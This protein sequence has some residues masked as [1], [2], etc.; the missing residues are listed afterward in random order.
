MDSFTCSNRT[1]PDFSISKSHDLSPCVGT[2]HYRIERY[3]YAYTSNM[4]QQALN[5]N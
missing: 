5:V 2:N 1:S 4:Q 3:Q